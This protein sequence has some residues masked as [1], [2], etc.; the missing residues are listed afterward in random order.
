MA[1]I[2]ADSFHAQLRAVREAARGIDVATLTIE[3]MRTASEAMMAMVGVMPDGVTV[4]ETTAAGRPALWVDAS[5]AD[6]TSVV[7]YLHGGAYI[8]NSP[9]SHA[10]LTGAIGLAAGC[11]VL[12]LDYRLAPEHPFPA[13]VDDA[14]A[15]YRWL[16]AEGFDPSR[17]AISG[18]SAGGGLTVATLVA[19]REAGLA[20]PAAG[21]V[22]SP[23]T[24][25][26]GV[27]ESM[28]TKAES[29]LL[30]RHADMAH[31]AAMYLGGADARSPLAAPIYADLTGIAPLYIQVGGDEVLLD[32]ATRLAVRASHAGVAVRLDVFPEM[33]HVFQAAVGMLPEADDAVARIGQHLRSAF[34]TQLAGR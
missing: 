24:E 31:V 30:I 13:A 3:Q 18:D 17:L 28:T 29:D 16:L 25:L 5:A 19:L 6:P 8:M 33:Q 26:E 10:R 20:Q 27:G 9:R 7:L 1:S 15:A 12:S 34:A 23:W 11:R 2:Q 21:V 4:S 22:L 14:V 32:D